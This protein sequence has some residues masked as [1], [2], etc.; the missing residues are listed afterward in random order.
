MVATQK[1]MALLPLGNVRFPE[2]G[3]ARD[4]YCIIFVVKHIVLNVIECKKQEEVSL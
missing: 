3:G 4:I 1:K 2:F